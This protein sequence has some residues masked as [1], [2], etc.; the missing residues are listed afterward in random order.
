MEFIDKYMYMYE[1]I[2]CTFG[3]KVHVHV[4]L[5]DIGLSLLH[6]QYTNSKNLPIVHV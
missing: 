6:I 2:Q 3:F 1:C 5:S 4:F